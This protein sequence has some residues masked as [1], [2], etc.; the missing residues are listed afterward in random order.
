MLDFACCDF[1]FDDRSDSVVETAMKYLFLFFL[2]FSAFA[3]SLDSLL[4]RT[5]NIGNL[6]SGIAGRL[7]TMTHDATVNG[8]S[9]PVDGDTIS[10]L[11]LLARSADNLSTRLSRA[12]YPLPE[13]V[14]EVSLLSTA[15]SAT[16]DDV[17]S[18]LERIANNT[19]SMVYSASVIERAVSGLETHFVDMSE[20]LSVVRNY[21]MQMGMYASNSDGYSVLIADKNMRQFEEMR[22]KLA[23]KLG[24]L[25]DAIVSAIKGGSV[26]ENGS[27]GPSMYEMTDAI[28]ADT[29]EME[30]QIKKV[31]GH[32]S[33]IGGKINEW[34]AKYVD[35]ND[36]YYVPF[37]EQLR[38]FYYRWA[39][40]LEMSNDNVLHNQ[41]S[42]MPVVRAFIVNP[43]D[44]AT[45]NL[46]YTE[47]FYKE[48][49]DDLDTIVSI[50]GGEDSPNLYS[51]FGSPG[52]IR[53]IKWDLSD[54]NFLNLTNTVPIL[55][56]ETIA[57]QNG[58]EK[59]IEIM[60][61]ACQV[62]GWNGITL[63]EIR[64]LMTGVN[65]DTPEDTL[66][67]GLTDLENKYGD[68][69]GWQKDFMS[70]SNTL[71]SVG[72]KFVIDGK[73]TV[74]TVFSSLG[75]SA[76]PSAISFNMPSFRL[77][78]VII[79]TMPVVSE[80][81]DSVGVYLDSVRN[82]CIFG[83]WTLAVSFCWGVARGCLW[84]VKVGIVDRFAHVASQTK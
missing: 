60:W 77:G 48:N 64:K 75:Q 65:D 25:Q 24:E 31:E 4:D 83:W 18:Y 45:N 47:R 26:Y 2:P 33:L 12:T 66:V 30:R 13:Y 28:A 58:L 9:V 39:N 74:D 67:D 79:E 14:D 11:E 76:A 59:M 20:L 46:P 7:R 29:D 23:T 1:G 61:T 37:A 36:L 56:D 52:Q 38:T 68:E 35:L 17:I 10:R 22:E 41:G 81:P 43:S 34:Y 15:A 19:D 57:G 69:D 5:V 44:S 16:I 42:G 50:M 21:T 62:S 73:Q 49:A 78:E 71:D 8:L 80:L 27:G 40:S 3:D 70:V 53:Y 72:R 63:N 51:S 6:S 54:P 82:V 55:A 32:L 84:L